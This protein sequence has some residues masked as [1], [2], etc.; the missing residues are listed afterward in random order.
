MGAAPSGTLISVRDADMNT[1]VLVERVH[2][3]VALR[4]ARFVRSERLTLEHTSVESVS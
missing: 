4:D 3:G 1:E 2:C